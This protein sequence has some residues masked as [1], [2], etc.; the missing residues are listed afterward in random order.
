MRSNHNTFAIDVLGI[1]ALGGEGGW[2]GEGGGRRGSGV[3][4]F[5]QLAMMQWNNK[6][7]FTLVWHSITTP[8]NYTC[9]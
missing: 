5:V 6:P 2:G 1:P 7:Y 8:S 4:N 9:T 3:S